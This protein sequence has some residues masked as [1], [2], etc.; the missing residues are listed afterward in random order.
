[1]VGG[2]GKDRSK[3][4]DW[5]RSRFLGMGQIC[6]YRDG[7]SSGIGWDSG[8]W[9]IPRFWGLDHIRCLWG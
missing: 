5:D 1:M 8:D 2:G 6:L 4:W 9:D 7:D 3:F